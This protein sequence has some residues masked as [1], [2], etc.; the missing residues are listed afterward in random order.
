MRIRALKP[1]FFKNEDLCA[2]SFCHRLAFEGLWCC[3]DRE[4]RLEDR[5]RRLK[6]EIFPY[7]D[8]DMDQV[9]ADLDAAKFIIRYVVDGRGL[10]WIPTWDDHQ[11]PRADESASFLPAY[12]Q[13]GVVQVTGCAT[14]TYLADT[15]LRLERDGSEAP[16]R[17]GNGRWE[18]GDGVRDMGSPASPVSS[19][20]TPEEFVSSW[21]AITTPPIPRCRELTDDRKRRVRSRLRV[22]P[23]LSFWRDVFARVEASAFCRGDS[24]RGWTASIDWILSNDTNAV[25]VLEGRYDT[26]PQTSRASPPTKA[27]KLT[28]MLAR[29]AALDSTGK[30]G[31]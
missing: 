7:D 8:V 27:D 17:M 23:E 25:K 2:L 11:H 19:S 24:D 16:A 3:A 20:V 5:P 4:G 30:Q 13:G 31:V 15:D 9:L 18:M 10:I 26:R 6:A 12:I 29:V 1:G 14:T 22:H 28:A 21:N